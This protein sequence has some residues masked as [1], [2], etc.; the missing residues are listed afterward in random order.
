MQP[1]YNLLESAVAASVETEGSRVK[2]SC[3]RLKTVLGVYEDVSLKFTQRRI[4]EKMFAAIGAPI[5][6]GESV[7]EQEMQT[8]T[9]DL[10]DALQSVWSLVSDSPLLPMNGHAN[11]VSRSAVTMPAP[12]TMT[13][14]SLLQPV[15]PAIVQSPYDPNDI[16]A[17]LAHAVR[18]GTPAPASSRVQ[19]V[20]PAPPPPAK[21][22]LDEAQRVLDEIDTLSKTDTQKIPP[23]KLALVLQALTAEARVLLGRLPDYHPAARRLVHSFRTISDIKDSRGVSAFINGLSRTSSGN[24]ARIASLSRKQAAEFDAQP[25]KFDP[26]PAPAASPEPVEAAPESAPAP[27]SEAAPKSKKKDVKS[28]PKPLDIKYP[29]LAAISQEAEVMLVGG[30]RIVEKVEWLASL[31]IKAEWYEIQKDNPRAAQSICQKIANR[32]AGAV[33]ILDYF[34]SHSTSNV[35]K[36]ACAAAKVQHTV[37][38]K[39]GKGALDLA[40]KAIELRLN[41]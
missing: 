15:S 31:G 19:V 34:M 38:D 41:N 20:R 33:I 25:F 2:A 37:A 9:N 18:A 23:A 5:P 24:W 11:D 8:C 1:I 6:P 29:R 26:E 32:K 17:V 30:L 12:S 39:G 4:V 21:E 36:S 16:D 35:L 27:V 40:L 3:A 22:D 14:P 28:E 7:T 10:R 13:P